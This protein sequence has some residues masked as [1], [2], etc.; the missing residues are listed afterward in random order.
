LLR[1][2]LAWGHGLENGWLAAETA[3]IYAPLSQSF[4]TKFD[5]TW[6]WHVSSHISS[7]MQVNLGTGSQGD[8]YAKLA[9]SAVWSV[10][11]K[12]KVEVGFV[13]ALTGD[14]GTGMRIGAWYEF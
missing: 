6:G 2:G 4:E 12:F 9:P 10:T 11:E 1:L 3:A 8:F 14:Q 13:Q 7:I 5:A